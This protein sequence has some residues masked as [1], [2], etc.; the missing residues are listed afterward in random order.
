MNIK[1]SISLYLIFGRTSILMNR[2]IHGRQSLWDK[3]HVPPNIWPGG[4]YHECP[5]NMYRPIRRSVFGNG[6]F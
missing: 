3:G 1:R 2:G 6:P 5:P 4:H